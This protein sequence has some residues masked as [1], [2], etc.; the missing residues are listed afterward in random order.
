M[1]SG[2]IGDLIKMPFGMMG[3]VDPRNG[4]MYNF[5]FRSPLC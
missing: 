5:G 4:T 2:K 3:R 1:N